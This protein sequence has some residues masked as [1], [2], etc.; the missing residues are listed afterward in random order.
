MIKFIQLPTCK[1][2]GFL[3]SSVTSFDVSG[4]LYNDGTTP[5]DPADIGDICFATIEPKTA[6][7]ELISFTIDSVT[8][9]GVATITATRGLSQKYP[10]GTGGAAFDHQSGSDFVISN[11]PGLFDKLAA[12]ANDEEITG[13]WSFPTPS[14]A[15]NPITKDYYETDQESVDATVVHVT[16]DEEIA[17]EKTFT[18]APKIPDSTADDEAVTRGE[19]DDEAVT[20]TGNQTIAGVKTF[21]SSP[22][23]P[24]AVNPNQPYTKGQHDADAEAASAVSSPT[25]RGTAKLDTAADNV[26]NPVVLTATADRVAALAGDA[27]PS[28]VNK[29]LTKGKAMVAGATINGATL[30]VPVYQNKTDNEFY[31]CDANDT[32]AMKFLGFAISNGTDGAAMNVQFSGIVSGFTG[33]SEGEKYYVQDTVGTIGTSIGTYEILVGVAISETELL[34]QKGKRRASGTTSL[35]GVSA[36]GSEVITC[37]FRPSKIR[38]DATTI[39]TASSGVSSTMSAVFLNGSIKGLSSVGDSG[40]VVSEAAIL[41]DSSSSN[42]LTFTITSITDTGFTIT[43]TETGNFSIT[44]GG[45]L[46]E[47]DGEL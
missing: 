16:G 11:N 5:V 6:R 3:G 40:G 47:A 44:D 35:A 26:L 36:S 19:F 20:L 23:V 33:L 7:E 2:S 30:P 27:T 43:Y 42:S 10:Y 17:G 12:K 1:L 14:V 32:A 15:N 37:G 28:A 41:Y 8:A 39:I 29:F 18:T 25:V 22:I 21:S 45:Y 4:F 38:I 34:I 24:D 9:A 13:S 46:W 31:A